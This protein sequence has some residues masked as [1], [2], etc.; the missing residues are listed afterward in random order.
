MSRPRLGI[1]SLFM[2]FSFVALVHAEGEGA[3]PSVGGRYFARRMILPVPAFAQDDPRWS[4][5]R[6]GPSTDTLGYEGCAVTSAAMVAAFY[7]IKTDPQQLNA[8]L[9]RTGGFTDDGLIHWS[10]VQ[11]IAPTRLALA[12]NGAPSYE[13]IDSNLLAGNPV[14]V[15]IRL[16]EG[17]YHFVVVVGKDGRDYL[18]RDPAASP[19]RRV[20]PLRDLT[21][22][23][24][25]LCFFRRN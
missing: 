12:Y 25:G 24:G 18:I 3:I 20:Y 22:R 13:L 23:I 17:G 5:V 2:A 6:L 8:F 21:D 4:D 11:L 9:T 7:G 16:P 19:Q 14:I 1:F 15:L 10:R